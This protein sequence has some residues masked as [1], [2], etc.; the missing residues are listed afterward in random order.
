MEQKDILK[1]VLSKVENKESKLYFFTMDTKGN[2]TAGIANIYEHVKLLN[3]NGFNA[4]ILHEKNDYN[5]V[6]SWLGSEYASLPH[7][8]IENQVSINP[9]D[10]L[11]IPEI[12]SNI[13]HDLRKYSCKKIVFSQNYHYILEL[14]APGAKW[15]DYGFNE[16]ITTSHQQADYIGSLF[17]NVNTNVVPVSIPDYFQP[18]KKPRKP[19]IGIL[20]REQ[21]DAL[22]IAKSFYLKYP[23]FKWVSFK[24]F[25]GLPRENFAEELKECCVAV[26]VDDVA[27]HGTFPLE[28]LECEIPV[29]AKVPNMVQEWMGN[30]KL[31]EQGQ[32]ESWTLNDNFL[33]TRDFLDIP[34]LISQYM[35]LWLTDD[36]PQILIDNIKNAKGQFTSEKQ[37]EELIKV[38]STLFA[39]RENELKEIILREENIQ[40]SLQN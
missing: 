18:S 6:E 10:F 23:I 21:G 11:I 8:C 25:R 3:E 5:S 26:W 34:K 35:N 37:K 22:K 27:G 13:M 20:T 32:P 7:V 9:E 15:S 17:P 39:K 33:W 28:A 1:N 2:P 12:F 16:V 24:E 4:T 40:P 31:N 38:Y 19:I 29:I 36:L 14:L 30:K